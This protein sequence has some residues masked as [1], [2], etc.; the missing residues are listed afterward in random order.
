MMERKRTYHG[1]I[2]AKKTGIYTVYVFQLDDNSYEMCTLLPNWGP[3]YQLPVGA[4]GFVTVLD[5]VAGETY[6]D[7]ESNTQKTYQFS[8]TY[9]QDFIKD[10]VIKDI[11]L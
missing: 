7:R 10:R 3:E 6:Y 9:F 2:V 11:I 5:A 8:K 4:V 1:K